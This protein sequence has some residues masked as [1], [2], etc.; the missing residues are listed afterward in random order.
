MARLEIPVSG[1]T[2]LRTKHV[3][4]VEW[5]RYLGHGCGFKLDRSKPKIVT[6]E[7]GE[8]TMQ[9]PMLRSARIRKQWK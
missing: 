6:I 4:L 3:M 2:C 7:S 8:Q 5:P 1:W 9:C